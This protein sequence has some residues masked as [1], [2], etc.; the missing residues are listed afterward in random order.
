MLQKELIHRLPFG[1][2]GD[3]E[4]E[5]HRMIVAPHRGFAAGDFAAFGNVIPAVGAMVNG[6]EQESFVGRVGRE[7]RVGEEILREGQA[8]LQIFFA[9]VAAFGADQIMAETNQALRGDG[10]GGTVDRLV[11]VEGIGGTREVITHLGETGRA[12]VPI[13][14][15]IGRGVA[16]P[17]VGDGEGNFFETFDRFGFRIIRG[18]FFLVERGEKFQLLRVTAQEPGLSTGPSGEGGVTLLTARATI[19][20]VVEIEDAFVDDPSAFV[21]NV[22]AFAE[23]NVV[24]RGGFGM[25]QEAFEQI[26]LRVALAHEAV[27]ELMADG[28]GAQGTDGVAEEGVRSVEGINVAELGRDLGPTGGLDGAGEFEGEF[29]EVLFPIVL[30]REAFVEEAQEIAVGADVIEAVVMHADVADVRGHLLDGGVATHGEELFLAGGIELENGG[31][32][33]ETLR[34]LRPAARGVF[35]GFGEDGGAGVGF[36]ALVQGVDLAGGELEDFVGLREEF[37]GGERGIDLEHI[38]VGLVLGWAE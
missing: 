23:V 18:E 20:A 4:R 27:A 1:F 33:L 7:I 8:G 28:E 21:V 5:F 3:Q 12:V 11:F 38:K 2:A 36:P 37:L 16:Q 26:D 17:E 29:V 34:P 15:A 6:M 32:E 13:G 9:G 14:N 30:G 24:T 19:T 22:A 25:L 10:G 35:A 31:A